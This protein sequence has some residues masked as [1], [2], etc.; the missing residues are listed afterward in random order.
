MNPTQS[1]A[2]PISDL[3]RR[4][5]QDM[6]NRSFGDKTRH[7]YIRHIESFA[8]FLGRSPDTATGDDVRQFQA[9]Q[10]S[11]GAQPPKMNTQA[12]ALR[13][14]FTVTLGRVDLAHQLARTHYPRKLVRVLS[15]DDVG[16]G[17]RQSR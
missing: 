12:S 6:T 4:M 3:R 14:F 1:I 2:K 13:F 5:L 17:A 11:N 10:I 8:K 9:Q 16:R 15:P 7:D